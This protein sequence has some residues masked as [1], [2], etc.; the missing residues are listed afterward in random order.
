MKKLLGLIL[1]SVFSLTINANEISSVLNGVSENSGESVDYKIEYN[2]ED[3]SVK[4]GEYSEIEF[5]VQTSDEVTFE[6]TS[7]MKPVGM[8]ITPLENNSMLLSGMPE[9]ISKFCFLLTVKTQDSDKDGTERVCLLA[10]KNESLNHPNFKTSTYLKSVQKNSFKEIDILVDENSSGITPEFIQG[11]LPEGLD[12]STQNNKLTISGKTSYEGVYQVLV[13]VLKQ[14]T[15]EEFYVYKQFQLE[16]KADIVD[17]YQ[18][19][20]GYYFDETL[21]YCVQNSGTACP[22]GTFYDPELNS[23]VDYQTPP[24][25]TCRVGTYY[26]HFLNRCVRDSYQR[27]P[28]NYEYDSYYNKCVRSASTCSIGYRYDWSF[29]SCIYIGN[30]SCARGSHYSTYRNRCVSN[31]AYCRAGQFWDGNTCRLNSRRCRNRAYYDPVFGS[32]RTRRSHVT[33]NGG[34][35]YNHGSLRCVRRSV[36]AGRTCR[37]GR[38]S[39]RNGSCVNHRPRQTRPNRPVVRPNRRR[40]VVVRPNRPTHRPTRPTTRPDRPTRPTTRPDRPTRPTRPTTRPDRPTR[41]TRPT[42][43]PDRPSRPSRPTTRPDRPSRPSRPT[44][45]PSRPSRPSQPS[46]PSRPSRPRP[47]N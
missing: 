26:D 18:C 23:C 19:D 27:C 17:R 44:A 41:P 11:E 38:Y 9:F 2:T 12:T 46:R 43:R 21:G 13:L 31:Y 15:E 32:C 45:R 7:E 35:R 39:P 4:Y 5:F 40:P 3:L 16:V 29:R 42:T 22:A 34:Y 6:I 36:Y 37:N 47:R 33:C 8:N 24:Q 20:I 30:R 1:L 14:T 28:Y 10:E 25:V